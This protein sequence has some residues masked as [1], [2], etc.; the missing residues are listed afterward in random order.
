MLSDK[1]TRVNLRLSLTGIF[2][3]EVDGETIVVRF[4]FFFPDKVTKTYP[5]LLFRKHTQEKFMYHVEK[6][7]LGMT[8]KLLTKFSF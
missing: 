3:K 8:F 1:L 4:Y 5:R 2:S 6:I 7:F